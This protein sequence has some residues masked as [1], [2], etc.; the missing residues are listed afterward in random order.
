MRFIILDCETAGL[1]PEQG[2]CEIAWIEI[3]EDFNVIDRQHSLIDPQCPISP[4]ASGI[5]GITNAMV[6]DSPTLDE[7]FFDVL[8]APFADG[9]IVFVAHNAQ[10]DFKFVK[11]YIVEHAGT[12][13]TLKLARILYPDAP[14]HK[15]QTLRY[16]LELPQNVTDSHSAAG[17]VEVTLNLLKHM[18]G[19]SGLDLQGLLVLAGAPVPIKE[20]PFGKH[21]GKPLAQVPKDYI[22][23]LLSEP[24]V[25]PDLRYA[26]ERL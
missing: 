1:K 22:K 4:N 9:D 6:E 21:K 7:F 8:D 10:F 16:Y 2:P 26:L 13:C 23:W 14:D 11:Q 18:A 24:N 25:D 5:H 19:K 17:D 3:D 15:L 12:I 20:M